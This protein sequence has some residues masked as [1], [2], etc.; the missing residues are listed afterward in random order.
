[1][2]T[3]RPI[4]NLTSD[5]ECCLTDGFIA[6]NH[7]ADRRATCRPIGSLTSDGDCCLTDGFIADNHQADRG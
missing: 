3:C 7:Q 1:M 5:K 4:G 6:N 2:A